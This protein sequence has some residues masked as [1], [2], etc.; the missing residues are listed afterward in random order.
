M[1]ND[2]FVY[3]MA[4]LFMLKKVDFP[5]TTAH[6]TEFFVERSYTDFLTLQQ[7]LSQILD[8]EFVTKEVVHNSSQYSIT[9]DGEEALEMFQSR[10]PEGMRDD[11]LDF[12]M[13]NEIKLRNEVDIYA[14]YIPASDNE[15]I[16]DC[17][18]KEK[19]STVISLKLNVS[20]KEEAVA[21]CDNWKEVCDDVYNYMM[22][23][24]VFRS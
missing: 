15:F 11:I 17:E 9:S 14:D 20:S 12:F 16:V 5:L 2:N 3:K 21:A 4:I 22:K 10:I 23:T 1:D 6:F 8:N 24:L 13:E 7:A 19:G 18:V